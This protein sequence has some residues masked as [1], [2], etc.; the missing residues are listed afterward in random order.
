MLEGDWSLVFQLYVARTWVLLSRSCSMLWTLQGIWLL[1][2]PAYWTVQWHILW[3]IVVVASRIV[4]IR[5]QFVRNSIYYIGLYAPFLGG[6]KMSFVYECFINPMFW[7][8]FGQEI[9][10]FEH[11]ICIPERNIYWSVGC[12]MSGKSRVWWFAPAEYALMVRVSILSC[13]GWYAWK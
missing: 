2:M 10:I 8:E 6:L 1:C 7:K 13:L 4:L 5:R 3:S 9:L 12:G 11:S